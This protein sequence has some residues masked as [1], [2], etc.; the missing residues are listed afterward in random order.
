MI[1][2]QAVTRRFGATTVLD[3]IDLTVA[4]GSFVA[5]LGPSGCG[6]STL[7]RLIAGL[8]RPTAGEIRIRGR[9]VEEDGPAGRNVAMVFQSY[10]LYPHL[11]VAQNIALPLAMRRLGRFGRSPLGALSR[12]VRETRRAI[13]REAADVARA[14][15]LDAL[16][17][18]KPAALSGG[19]K[20]RVALARAL[21][22]DP[23]AFLLDEP[24]SNLDAR[25]RVQMRAEISALHRRT[26]R[27]FIHVTHDQSE[28]MGMA[29][30]VAVMLEGRIAQEGP[31]RELYERPASRAVAAFVG[32]H[33]INLVPGPKG[34]GLPADF[35]F[36]PAP[37]GGPVVVGLRP[38]HLRPR[39]GGRLSARLVRTE[40]QGQE[41]LVDLVLAD[42]TAMRATADAGWPV[43]APG[44]AF[45]LDFAERDLHA[46]DAADGRRLVAP[47]AGDMRE[48][49][50]CA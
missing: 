17:A 23:V 34:G 50:A 13:A 44:D 20:Q 31:P 4:E 25:L 22:R 28:A 46:F 48:A 30:R 38:E 18:R 47:W 41:I 1:E 15:E 24:L 42:G 35:S 3:G 7:L 6:K 2:L 11:T 9:N 21:V 16:L 14:L 45:S 8:D 29:D 49:A 36:L 27:T 12:E 43:P 39:A 5:L 19:Q 32:A 40:Y 10:A 37:K 26:G 33:P